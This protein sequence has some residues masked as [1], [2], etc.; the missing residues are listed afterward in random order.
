MAQR[1]LRTAASTKRRDTCGGFTGRYALYRFFD[2]QGALLYI[3]RTNDMNRRGDHHAR[4]Q[5]WWPDV[6]RCTV[7]FLADFEALVDAEI[8]AILAEKPRHNI[9]HNGVVVA[10]EHESEWRN[11][12]LTISARV[13]AAADALHGDCRTHAEDYFA[14]AW[15]QPMT[16][17]CATCLT[18]AA[19]ALTAADASEGREDETIPLVMSAVTHQKWI[20]GQRN[21]FWTVVPCTCLDCAA[22]DA[23]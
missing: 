1:G 18:N 14:G 6:A 12:I 22:K 15:R 8:A 5:G 13:T 4:N 9:I 20:R 3:G 23:S 10:P 17:P 16:A 21:P 11:P 19:K 2:A 7:E